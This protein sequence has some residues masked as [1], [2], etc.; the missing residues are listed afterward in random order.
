MLRTADQAWETYGGWS[1]WPAFNWFW[2][3][4]VCVQ[5]A[6][7]LYAKNTFDTAWNTVFC[8]CDLS[9]SIVTNELKA[10]SATVFLFN[11]FSHIIWLEMLLFIFCMEDIRY[12]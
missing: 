6:D 3:P 9:V 10:V 5:F 4:V 12:I 2:K 1:E 8:K 11:P 7:Y